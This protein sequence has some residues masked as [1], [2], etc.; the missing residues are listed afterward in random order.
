MAKI[1][2]MAG[3]ALGALAIAKT[4]FGK[5]T[6]DL[7]SQGGSPGGTGGSI[8]EIR[9]E[10]LNVIGI[11]RSTRG[12]VMIATPG[13]MR[14]Y[15]AS[16]ISRIMGFYAT[17]FNI[18]GVTLQT[19]DVKR[20]GVGVATKYPTGAVM[21]DVTISFIVDGQGLIQKFFHNWISSIANYDTRLNSE[22]VNKYG[23][24]L[25]E[26]GYKKD[27]SGAPINTTTAVLY[28]NS[29]NTSSIDAVDPAKPVITYTL[30]GLY[31]VAMSDV[32][33]S[34]SSVNGLA[35]LTVRFAYDNYS[36]EDSDNLS[37]KPLS[38]TLPQLSGMQ[39]II[40]GATVVQTVAALKRPRNV[41]DIISVVNNTAM[42]ASVIKK[43]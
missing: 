1:A 2:S 7:S 3:G 26:V 28:I 9:S 4:Y 31:P 40:R 6:N 23:A 13:P 14:N 21:P 34:W 15:A 41:N 17:D 12:S 20:Y 42:V 32:N 29:E 5:K 18:P 33:M 36:I 27:Q 10:A 39:Q 43:W 35:T 30:Q 8:S 38:T 25:F 37:A 24:N 16:E 11:A 22:S 19:V